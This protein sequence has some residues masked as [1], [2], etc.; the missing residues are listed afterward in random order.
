[1]LIIFQQ[2]SEQQILDN[3][4]TPGKPVEGSSRCGFL[5]VVLGMESTRWIGV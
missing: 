5:L 1:M 4:Q 2:G 3:Q